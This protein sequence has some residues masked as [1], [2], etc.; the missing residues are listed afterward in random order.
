MTLDHREHIAEPV[1]E[2]IGGVVQPIRFMVDAPF[3]MAD[4]ASERF[5]T[6]HN[7]IEENRALRE[8]NL[9]YEARLQ[10]F[11]SLRTENERLRDLLGSSARVEREVLV[12]ELM[13]IDLDPYTH[14]VQINRG[15]RSGVH[16]GQPVL[17]ANGIMGQV[18][19]T[20][21]TSATVRLISDPSHAVPVE[22]DRNGL[23]AVA[24][25]T[26][27][28]NR[29]ELA[30]VPNNA[31]IQEGDMLLAS[32]LGGKFPRGYPVARVSQIVIEPGEPFARVAAEPLAALDRSR[33]VL[34]LRAEE[35]V[36]VEQNGDVDD[37]D[38]GAGDAPEEEDEG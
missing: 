27:D 4:R 35:F 3:R 33:E 38:H 11:E 21:P 24:I 31:D 23:R 34:L 19:Q 26:G 22:V 18:D 30:N 8:T 36:D 6:R 29:L 15:S 16:V 2:A 14:L 25:G 13:R 28:L 9:E 12:A 37:D 10:R 1:R 7:L 32:G 20:S 17:D 5:A